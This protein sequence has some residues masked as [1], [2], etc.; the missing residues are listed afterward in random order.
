MR[1]LPKRCSRSS[2]DSRCEM[3]L[4]THALV[5][6]RWRPPKCAVG[7]C[8]C[9][10]TC[11][12][13]G[14]ENR[15]GRCSAAGSIV[16]WRCGVDTCRTSSK[17]Q[18]LADRLINSVHQLRRQLRE[19]ALD[20]PTIVDCA[21]LIDQQVRAAAEPSSR[22]HMHPE[23]FSSG[24]HIRRQGHDERG[25]MTGIEKRLRLHNEH[26]ACLTWLGATRRVQVRQPDLASSRHS[27]RARSE[28]TL[29]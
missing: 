23:R 19:W 16:S 24:N 9:P 15:V 13:S 1:R 2:A 14:A 18:H 6:V 29:R 4:W 10:Q 28:R 22:R 8:D 27:R 25:R 17:L 20:K 5:A 26:R 12:H 21:K 11:P 7:R 3:R